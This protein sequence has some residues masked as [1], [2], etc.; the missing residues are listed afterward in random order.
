MVYKIKDLLNI[1]PSKL[2]TRIITN[3]VNI[4][5]VKADG[6]GNSNLF[7]SV[8]KRQR[9]HIK[10]KLASVKWSFNLISVNFPQCYVLFTDDLEPYTSYF[11]LLEDHFTELPVLGCYRRSGL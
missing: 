10:E 6:R 11:C 1:V 4:P 9:N 7:Q 5:C 3:A 2:Q 8:H